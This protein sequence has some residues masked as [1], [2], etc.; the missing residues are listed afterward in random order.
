MLILTSCLEKSSPVDIAVSV[1]AA[2]DAGKGGT[3]AAAR[4]QLFDRII[5][6][7]GG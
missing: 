6:L 3:T 2:V 5:E 4:V 1:E 7:L